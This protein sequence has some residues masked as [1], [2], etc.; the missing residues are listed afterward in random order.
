MM[1]KIDLTFL[2]Y[3]FPAWYAFLAGLRAM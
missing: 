3:D 1:V 2:L